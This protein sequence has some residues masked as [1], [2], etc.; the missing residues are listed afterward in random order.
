M[1]IEEIRKNA[2]KGA[3]GYFEHTKNYLK[4]KNGIWYVWFN[5][6]WL[7]V[8]QMTY[9]FSIMDSIKPLH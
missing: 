3:T 7:R 1:T 8:K 4:N 5:R 9:L 6:R 2:P